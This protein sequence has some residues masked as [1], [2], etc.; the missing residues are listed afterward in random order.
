MSRFYGNG[1]C[2]SF[3]LIPVLCLSLSVLFSTHDSDGTP[4]LP[5]GGVK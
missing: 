4:G 2:L 5:L 3:G 1:T